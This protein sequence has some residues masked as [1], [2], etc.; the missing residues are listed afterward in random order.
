MVDLLNGGDANTIT[1]NLAAHIDAGDNEGKIKEI[2]WIL[3]P[4][5]LLLPDLFKYEHW[6]V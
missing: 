1:L 6:I 3:C 5:A 2:E 4:V